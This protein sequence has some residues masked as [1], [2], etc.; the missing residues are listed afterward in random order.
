MAKNLGIAMILMLVLVSGISAQDTL[1]DPKERVEQGLKLLEQA[2]PKLILLNLNLQ[3]TDDYRLLHDL[4][5]KMAAAPIPVVAI[6]D[7]GKSSHSGDHEPARF[8]D[9]LTA[10]LDVEKFFGMLDRLLPKA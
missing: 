4:R 7:E 5:S 3:K 10:P 1:S 6:A 8:A 2:Q 9:Y